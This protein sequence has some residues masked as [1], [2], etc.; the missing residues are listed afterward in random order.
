MEFSQE[1]KQ[2]LLQG[3]NVIVK[4]GG[5]NTSEKVFELAE[6]IKSELPEDNQEE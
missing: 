2:I 6:K 4:Q 1:E 5:L 3:L